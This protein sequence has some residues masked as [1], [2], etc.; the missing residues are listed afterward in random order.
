MLE[1]V[2]GWPQIIDESSPLVG[3]KL[4]ATLLAQLMTDLRLVRVCRGLEA[5]AGA[6]LGAAAEASWCL[7]GLLT[8]IKVIIGPVGLAWVYW[9]AP[10]ARWRHL[11]TRSNSNT[12]E[13]RSSP[14]RRE[15][16]CSFCLAI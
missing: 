2:Q 13:S 5:R 10:K 9:G 1:D 3:P 7:G 4:K 14:I 6:R 15:I 11:V 16:L 8:Q 12:C